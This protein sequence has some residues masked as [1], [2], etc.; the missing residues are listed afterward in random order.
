[1]QD[2]RP[3]GSVTSLY[4]NARPGQTLYVAQPGQGGWMTPEE[5]L[6][7]KKDQ[8]AEMAA[9]RKAAHASVSDAPHLVL[10]M[11]FSAWPAYGG[12]VVA[13]Y[14]PIRSELDPRPA[15]EAYREAGCEIVLPV[16]EK[17]EA[18]LIFRRWAPGDKLV[19]GPFKTQEPSAEAE[20]LTPD[21]ILAPMLAFDR[22]GYRLGYGGGFY[23]RTLAKL[24]ASG[25]PMAI[26]LAYSAQEV[27][28]A[29]TGP[30][31]APLDGIATEKEPID[32]HGV[33]P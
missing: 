17:P 9:R 28:R 12:A 18:P 7:A 31:D 10:E 20:E 1:M 8:R 11:L 26:G 22:N 19:E 33:A 2:Q 16:I 5:I 32:T 24:R 25:S 15:M 6:Q 4:R 30:T 3:D 21:I 23:D 13:G 14:L 27:D 29:V